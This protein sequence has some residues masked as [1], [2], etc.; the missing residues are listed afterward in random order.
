[1]TDFFADLEREIRAAHPRRSRPAVP[2]KGLAVSAAVAATLAAVVLALGQLVG[3]EEGE[4]ATPPTGSGWTEYAPLNGCGTQW[5]RSSPPREILDRFAVLRA[6]GNRGTWDGGAP[7]VAARVYE[8][9]VREVDRGGRS[10]TVIP[11][12]F[13]SDDD[14]RTLR[15]GVCLYE[16]GGAGDAC[17]VLP[18]GDGLMLATFTFRSGRRKHIAVLAEDAVADVRIDLDVY[19]TGADVEDNVLH[20]TAAADDADGVSVRPGRVARR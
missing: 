17:A 8:A 2:V 1:M 12:D 14:C 13:A 19:A 15:P 7:A 10:F 20:I 16:S 11:V 18:E 4:V 6:P 3:A 9:A 5:V